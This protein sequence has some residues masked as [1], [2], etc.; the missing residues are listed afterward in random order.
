MAM[1]KYIIKH[2]IRDAL[3][4]IIYLIIV[5]SKFNGTSF[6]LILIKIYAFLELNK[7]QWDICAYIYDDFFKSTI[8]DYLDIWTKKIAF[9]PTGMSSNLLPPPKIIYLP[10]LV[11]SISFLSC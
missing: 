2:V 9:F 7:K 10:K 6:G 3:N 1:Q 4:F 11:F 5:L 8:H